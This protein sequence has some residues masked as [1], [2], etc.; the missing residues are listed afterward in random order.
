MPA[1]PA[2]RLGADFLSSRGDSAWAPVM[3][4]GASFAL[5][6]FYLIRAFHL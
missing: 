2:R 5:G 1:D 6:A 4:M 3:L